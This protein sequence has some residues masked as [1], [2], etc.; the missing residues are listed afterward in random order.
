MF[1]RIFPSHRFCLCIICF[2]IHQLHRAAAFRIFGALSRVVYG[3]SF[4]QVRRPSSIKTFIPAF[5]DIDI[6]HIPTCHLYFCPCPPDPLI[7][8]IAMHSHHYK[9]SV[10]SRTRFS[11]GKAK[12]NADHSAR[13]TIKTA[14]HIKYCRTA[15]SLLYQIIHRIDRLSIFSHLKVYIAAFYAVIDRRI[16]N[17]TKYRLAVYIIARFYFHVI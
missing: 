9:T 12:K 10:L 6:I 4:F 13:L 16:S 2:R 5:Y 7:L 3:N 8:R 17:I 11:D 15:V 14:R 1:D